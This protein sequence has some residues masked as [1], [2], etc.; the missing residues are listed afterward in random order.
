M[1]TQ[2]VTT[3]HISYT[4]IY[5]EQNYLDRDLDYINLDRSPKDASF[6]LDFH[7]SI[8]KVRHIYVIVQ[9]LFVDPDCNPSNMW[10]EI[11]QIAILI[12][13]L[14]ETKFL[15][16]DRNLDRD[17]YIILPHEND[18]LVSRV[19]STLTT[20]VLDIFIHYLPRAT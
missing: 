16:P 17:P 15:D 14:Q 12:E 7:C 4:P 1:H 11:F 3:N 6:T 13:C 5:I 20:T 8:D 2:K 9:S 10:I 18:V 19:F